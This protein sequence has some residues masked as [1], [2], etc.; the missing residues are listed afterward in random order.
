MKI[1]FPYNKQF[2]SLAIMIV[3]IQSAIAQDLAFSQFFEAPLLRNPSL[4]G[5]FTGDYRI[6][7]C[8]AIN[9][10]V[11]RMLTELVLLM[12]NI[13]CPSDKAMIFLLSDC[14]YYMI[15]QAL[16]DLLQTKFFRLLI[17]TNH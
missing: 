1:L 11:L 2:A 3:F 15:R 17:I 7:E 12:E 14:R 4:A 6:Q 5:I 16:P 8:I 9:G 13:K 10:T